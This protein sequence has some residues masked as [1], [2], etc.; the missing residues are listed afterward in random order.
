MS[1]DEF[2]QIRYYF[3]YVLIT[4]IRFSDKLRSSIIN[5]QLRSLHNQLFIQRMFYRHLQ[6]QRV[7]EII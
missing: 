4:E 6:R 2:K 5:V 1:D 7:K 3:K